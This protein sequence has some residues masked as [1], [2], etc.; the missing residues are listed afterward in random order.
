[1][2]A[3]APIQFSYVWFLRFFAFV[4]VLTLPYFGRAQVSLPKHQLFIAV[5]GVTYKGSLNSQYGNLSPGVEVGLALTSKKRFNSCLSVFYGSV[6]GQRDKPI[7]TLLPG[8]STISGTDFFE[9]QLLAFKY[10]L[11]YNFWVGKKTRYWASAGFGL[12]R[13]NPK[14]ANGKELINQPITRLPGET[15]D[16]RMTQLPVFFGGSY[17]FSNGWQAVGQLGWWNLQGQ[18]LDN[19][20]K[21]RAEASDNLFQIKIGLQI[22]LNLKKEAQIP[23]ETKPQIWQDEPQKDS[24]NP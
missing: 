19:T 24:D 11:R 12:V 18:Y 20:E 6:S 9:T 2:P 8:V 13:Y 1:M 22:P 23:K 7:S 14:D 15:Y 4:A 3:S 21:H 5:G 16:T 17:L 10:E